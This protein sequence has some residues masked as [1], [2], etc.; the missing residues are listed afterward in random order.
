[1][2]GSQLV[3]S[4]RDEPAVNYSAIQDPEYK[5]RADSIYSVEMDCSKHM[6]LAF[7][8]ELTIS[9][10]SPTIDAWSLTGRRIVGLL[11]LRFG[12]T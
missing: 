3:A 2:Q 12:D 10:L 5:R 9:S 6:P 8:V 11:P 4:A 1:M 7:S